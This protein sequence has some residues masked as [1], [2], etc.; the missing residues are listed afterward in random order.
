VR[1]LIIVLSRSIYAIIM[2]G[3]SHPLTRAEHGSTASYG[4]RNDMVSRHRSR[5]SLQ[6]RMVWPGISTKIQSTKYRQLFRAYVA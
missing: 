5:L 2:S 6:R 1:L 3:P 4:Y